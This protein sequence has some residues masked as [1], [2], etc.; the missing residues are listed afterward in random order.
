MEIYLMLNN[1]FICLIFLEI[2]FTTSIFGKPVIQ[3]GSYRYFKAS[4][5]DGALVTWRCS[6]WRTKCC[7]ATITTIENTIIRYKNDHTH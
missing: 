2:V 6:K 3:I 4:W 5:R 7:R 1:T